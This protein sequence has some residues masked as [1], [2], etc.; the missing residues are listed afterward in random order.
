M[1]A[2]KSRTLASV[3]PQC[4]LK[5]AS[6]RL[7]PRAT[8]AKQVRFVNTDEELGGV[9]PAP[10]PNPVNWKAG[11][12]TAISILLASWWM[13]SSKSRKARS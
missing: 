8:P 9:P 2:S 12:I 7:S 1:I 13:L 6:A 10:Q 11:T 5:H 4:A 3:S